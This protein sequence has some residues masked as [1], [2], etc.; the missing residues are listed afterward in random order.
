MLDLPGLSSGLGRNE[1]AAILARTW[2][3]LKE[4]SMPRDVKPLESSMRKLQQRVKK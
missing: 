4:C 3:K 2:D 1:E